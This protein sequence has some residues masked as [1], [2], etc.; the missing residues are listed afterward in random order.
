M[1]H[2]LNIKNGALLG[3]LPALAT[4]PTVYLTVDANGIISSRTL[5]Q[6]TSDLSV[7]AGSS[8]WTTTGTAIYYNTGNVLVG[9][10]TDSGFKLDI[11]GTA[12]FA[13]TITLA[14]N[15]ATVAP[16]HFIP[17][18]AVLKTTAV[19]GDMEV[20]VNGFPYYSIQAA[21]RGVIDTAQFITLTTA[22]TT[23]AGTA[24]TLKQLF[25]SP[26]GGALTVVGST[27]YFFEC[28]F[29]LSALSAT[30]GT[31]S[32]GLAGNATYTRILYNVIGLKTTSLTAQNALTSTYTVATASI[33]GSAT[34]NTSTIGFAYIRGKI[35]VGTGGTIIP[36][37]TSSVAAACIVGND[38]YF[39]L[40]P[41]GINT[42]QSV[43]NWA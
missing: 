13:N 12:R 21:S 32:F 33:V 8:Q 6:V 5:A 43:G 30:S 41:A 17:T 31:F 38:S 4:T 26:A 29:T 2:E 40:F 9:T 34:G 35:V 11:N 36:S 23:P 37:I 42:V 18:S 10:I 16:L 7:S 3:T 14:T 1:A 15:T 19:A 20:D 27:T 24:N 28:Y 25:N 39:R 22:Y